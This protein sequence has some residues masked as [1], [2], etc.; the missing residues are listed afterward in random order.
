MSVDMIYEAKDLSQMQLRVEPKG[1]Y[2]QSVSQMQDQD[3][4]EAP[5]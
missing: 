1:R 5:Q 4:Y 3:G 2:A